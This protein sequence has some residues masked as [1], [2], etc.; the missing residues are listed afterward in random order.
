M[1]RSVVVGLLAAV[2]AA[3]SALVGLSHGDFFWATFGGAAVAAGL[4][5]ALAAGPVSK[6]NSLM[7]TIVPSMRIT[8]V[9]VDKCWSG[10][11]PRASRAWPLA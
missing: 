11:S 9:N 2:A 10:G 7:F 8:E 3:M 1:P 4:G 5:G 6:K